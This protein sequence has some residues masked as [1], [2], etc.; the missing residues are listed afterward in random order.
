MGKLETPQDFL[1]SS[2][3][4]GTDTRPTRPGGATSGT[5]RRATS[6]AIFNGRDGVGLT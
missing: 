3:H 4:I 5:A 1:R 6:F 2:S